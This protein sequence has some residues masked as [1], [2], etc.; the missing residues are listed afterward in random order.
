MLLDGDSLFAHQVTGSLRQKLVEPLARGPQGPSSVMA[1]RKGALEVI[2]ERREPRHELILVQGRSEQP[3][4]AVDV[5][6]NRGRNQ[7]AVR[8]LHRQCRTR[9][10]VLTLL[11]VGQ[12]DN[13]GRATAYRGQVDQRI[14]SV[15]RDPFF[16]KGYV[17]NQSD[18]DLHPAPKPPIQLADALGYRP[19]L[20]DENH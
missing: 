10:K 15:L 13:L 4:P 20:R 18:R 5:R 6:S 11:E 14:Q 3:K 1:D 19:P 2:E 7:K 9:G 8:V 12:T 17:R 16:K